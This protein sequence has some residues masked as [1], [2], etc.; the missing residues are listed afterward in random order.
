MLVRSSVN[1]HLTQEAELLPEVNETHVTGNYNN[2]KVNAKKSQPSKRIQILYLLLEFLRQQL[3]HKH[4]SGIR[5]VP[6]S[7]LYATP[8]VEICL[9]EMS[10]L[11]A[12]AF[13]SELL[14]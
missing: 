10:A 5:K 13:K 3:L 9:P 12:V 6:D 2:R 8:A 1:T 11:V 14:G 4:S 7:V